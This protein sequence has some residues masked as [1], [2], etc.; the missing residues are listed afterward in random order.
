[1]FYIIAILSL[2]VLI[3]VFTCGVRSVIAGLAI[4]ILVLSAVDTKV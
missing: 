3:N 1:M 4:S 2:L